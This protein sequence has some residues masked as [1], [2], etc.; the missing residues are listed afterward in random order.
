MNLAS[1]PTTGSFLWR[2][3][4]K[5][6]PVQVVL[7][8]TARCNF[9]CRMCF[10]WQP[11]ATA[12]METEWRPDELDKLAR[13]MKPFPWLLVGGG[14]PFLRDDLV[15]IIES[16]IRHNRVRFVTIPTNGWHTERIVALVE[17]LGRVY[18]EVKLNID[19][20]FLGPEES[21]DAICG[22]PG[23]YRRLRETVDALAS[24]RRR[25]RHFGLGAIFTL[26]RQNQEQAVA[27]LQT[28]TTDF[29]FDSVVI[30][31]ARGQCREADSIAVD[32]ARYAE[33]CRYLESVNEQG[34]LPGFHGSLGPII[35]AKDALLHRL[36]AARSEG[37]EAPL[38]CLAAR[39]S[40]VISETGV[41]FPCEMLNG[42]LGR[43]READLNF[44]AVWR[45]AAA[46]RLRESIRR[47]PCP[48]T[49]EC[50]QTLNLLLGPRHAWRILWRAL[51]RPRGRG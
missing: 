20:S 49:H 19:L 24:S 50:F 46:R 10:Y 21:H 12:T 43:L 42:E 33:A 2:A 4:R 32:P 6:D 41:V 48:C 22:A 15:P 1:W 25:Y 37:R 38:P 16:F 44:Q 7:F 36:I 11:A 27:T 18:P 29:A 26:C 5:R 9:R 8:V 47:E 34:R 35:Q 51:S 23:A 3:W 14:E 31:K 17:A 45:S 30:S 28:L 39:S 13:G 40:V